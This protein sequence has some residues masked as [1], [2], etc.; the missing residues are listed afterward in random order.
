MGLPAAF[1]E[2]APGLSEATPGGK[3]KWGGGGEVGR[4]VRPPPSPPSPPPPQPPLPPP[5]R[6]RHCGERISVWRHP[7]TPA[8]AL[9]LTPP[10]CLKPFLPPRVLRFLRA[11]RPPFLSFTPPTPPRLISPLGSP[12]LHLPRLPRRVP[13]IMRAAPPSCITGP[14]CALPSPPFSWEWAAS[15]N[16]CSCGGSGDAR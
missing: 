2:A 13:A 12:H 6:P 10:P 3:L 16:R 5:Q 14:V 1:H 8:A 11:A 15:G 7:R 4:T 9:S